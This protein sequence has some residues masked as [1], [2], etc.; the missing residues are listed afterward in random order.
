MFGISNGVIKNSHSGFNNLKIYDCINGVYSK[1]FAMQQGEVDQLLNR[2][3]PDKQEVREKIKLNIDEW[4]NGY[5][6]KNGKKLYSIF[7]TG[8][9]ISDCERSYHY[10]CNGEEKNESEW[11][12]PEPESYWGKSGGTKIFEYFFSIGFEGKF[13]YFLQDLA[14]GASTYY[15]DYKSDFAPLLE[16]PTNVQERSEILFH[17]LIH[18]G[19]LTLDG[20]RKN[21]F[22]IPNKEIED[23]FLSQ[24]NKYLESIQI[25]DATISALAKAVILEDFEMFGKILTKSINGLIRD[26]PQGKNDTSEKLMH[27][28]ILKIL[29]KLK[30]SL[31]LLV[32]NETGAGGE[33]GAKGSK[34]DFEINSTEGRDKIYYII[35][36]ETTK[37]D[38]SEK[39]EK[40]ALVGLKQIFQ[41]DSD[42]HFIPYCDTKEVVAM[43]ISTYYNTVCLASVKVSVQN[44]KITGFEKLKHQRFWIDVIDANSINIKA[45]ERKE[46]EFKLDEF[47]GDFKVD[48]TS[49]KSLQEYHRMVDDEVCKRIDFIRAEHNKL[50]SEPE[51]NNQS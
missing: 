32:R 6:D 22:R 46:H 41:K 13:D 35:E 48:L 40:D 49:T 7:S 14:Q 3:F 25:D 42:R 28:L 2:L 37:K 20:K 18:F 17:L 34:A 44:G 23:E 19:Y 43:G 51:L 36:L 39:I 24:L 29:S 50:E 27:G 5:N 1:Y 4:Y 10:F 15:K 9:Y 16:N 12:P 21:Y 30:I 31:R 8:L 38:N 11:D 33:D 45:T 26:I 47:V